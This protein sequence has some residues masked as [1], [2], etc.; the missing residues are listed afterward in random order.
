[1]TWHEQQQPNLYYVQT[2]INVKPATHYMH[3]THK[4]RRLVRYDLE[5]TGDKLDFIGI[6]IIRKKISD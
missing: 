3:V 1:V 2:H 4:L 5:I 6:L